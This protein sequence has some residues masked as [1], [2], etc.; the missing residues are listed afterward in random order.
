MTV[1]SNDQPEGKKRYYIGY[2][3]PKITVTNELPSEYGRLSD[4]ELRIRGI[5]F[6]DKYSR[7]DVDN[8][9]EDKQQSNS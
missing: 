6:D 1:Q 8:E 4:K 2:H 3:K 7:G 5:P 9:P